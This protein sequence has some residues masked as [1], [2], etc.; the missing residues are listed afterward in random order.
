MPASGIQKTMDLE[1]AKLFRLN[2][3]AWGLPDSGFGFII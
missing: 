3:V 1:A 2:N